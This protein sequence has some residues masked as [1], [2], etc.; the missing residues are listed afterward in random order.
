MTLSGTKLS[1]F[2]LHE[3]RDLRATDGA[4]VGLGMEPTVKGIIEFLLTSWTHWKDT[5]RRFVT[6]VRNILYDG[7]AWTAISAVDER[8]PIASVSRI[9]EFMQTIVAGSGVRRDQ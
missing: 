6:I 1:C 2:I 9:E 4:G 3:Q 5:H 8:I 7:E